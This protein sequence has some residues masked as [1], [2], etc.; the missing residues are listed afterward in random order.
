MSELAEEKGVE[1][2][3]QS[4]NLQTIRNAKM[5]KKLNKLY[6]NSS[7]LMM[8]LPIVIKTVIFS[9]VPMLWFVMAFQDYKF[10]PLFGKQNTWVW[11]ENF[12]YFFTSGEIWDIVGNT[13]GLNLMFIFIGTPLTAI[14]ALFMNEMHSRTTTK[15]FQT[16]WFIPYLIS[17]SVAQYA[18]WGIMES[19]GLINTVL[20]HLGMEPIDFYA[21]SSTGLWPLILFLWNMWKGQ[22][23]S[24]ILD[25][26]AL[27]SLD[28]GIMEAAEL[29]GA[30]RL[31]RMWYIEVPH[32]RK[33]VAIQLIMSMGGIVKSDFGMFWFLPKFEGNSALE[34]KKSVEVL[35]VRIYR[36]V[37]DPR[38]KTDYSK[39]TAIGLIQSIVGMV[40]MLATNWIV[41]KLDEESAFI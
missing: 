25:Y 5:R 22:G 33:I 6:R 18:S 1:S 3:V 11:F 15:V 31:Q 17:W 41:K 19:N 8:C 13:V 26:A 7:Y 36:L 16:I 24:V 12:E 4:P 20:G 35:D 38:I 10:P 9:I 21:A 2:E 30:T 29:D 14:M 32:L 28:T 40:I 23:Y 37:N 39:A 34:L 27:Q